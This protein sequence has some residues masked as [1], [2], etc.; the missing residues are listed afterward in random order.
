[1]YEEENDNEPVS[2]LAVAD[3]YVQHLNETLSF[4]GM[5]NRGATL[6]IHFEGMEAVSSRWRKGTT[7][8]EKLQSLANVEEVTKQCLSEKERAYFEKQARIRK[9]N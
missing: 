2:P 3:Y 8:K 4:L 7:Y 6:I 9:T 1:M 5:H